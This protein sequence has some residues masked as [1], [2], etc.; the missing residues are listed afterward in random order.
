MKHPKDTLNAV[1]LSKA[2]WIALLAALQI[3]LSKVV[4]GG[5]VAIPDEGICLN[6][7]KAV[8]NSGWGWRTTDQTFRIIQIVAINWKHSIT[9]GEPSA[10]PVPRIPID[11]YVSCR[12]FWTGANRDLRINLMRYTIKRMRDKIRR[13]K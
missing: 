5:A 10:Y 12:H 7:C 8:G 11:G 6:W 3:L 13:M 2:E 1:E 9:P 4:K